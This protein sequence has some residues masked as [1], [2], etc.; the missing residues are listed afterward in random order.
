MHLLEMG[1]LCPTLDGDRPNWTRRGLS[2]MVTVRTG[3]TGTP[4][5][6][7]PEQPEL[8]RSQPPTICR[9][10]AVETISTRFASL[11]LAPLG[12]ASLALLVRAFLRRLAHLSLPPEQ[13]SEAV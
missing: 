9:V 4:D 8:G 5:L 13:C 3:L 1:A 12:L 2:P 6:G 11:S 7:R 10:V